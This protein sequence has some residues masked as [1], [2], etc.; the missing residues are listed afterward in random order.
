MIIFP[1]KSDDVNYVL[2]DIFR[3]QKTGGLQGNWLDFRK[4]PEIYYSEYF[5][6]KKDW[7]IVES[8]NGVTLFR[9]EN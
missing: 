6:N 5:N 4:N 8:M 3:P 9:K 1:D 7:S 2:I